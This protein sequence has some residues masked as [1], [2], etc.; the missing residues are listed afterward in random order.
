MLVYYQLLVTFA[1]LYIF[2]TALY[3]LRHML[4][5]P[6]YHALPLRPPL[7]SVLIPARNEELNIRLCLESLMA[8]DYP[9]LEIIVLDDGSS[10]TTSIIVQEMSARHQQVRLIHGQPL[11][12]DWHGKAW[13]CD[14]LSREAQGE[15]LLFVDADTRHRPNSISSAMALA[16]AHG[17]DLLSLLPDMALKTSGLRVI[18]SIIPFVF[19]AC[20]PHFAFSQTRWPSFAAAV[21]P[22]M[23]FRGEVYHKFGG[24]EAVRRDIV[25]DVFIA[26][27]VKRV[28]GR[29]ALAD[30]VS[31]LR[32]EFY[33][34][35]AE[36]WHGLAKS[37]FPTF[38]YSSSGL[39][40]ALAASALVLLGPYVFIYGAWRFGWIDWVHFG[41]PLI[42]ILL[43]CMAMVFVDGRFLVPRRYGLLVAL[44]VLVAILFCL[45]SA[46]RSLFG[47][48][49]VWK[50]R[51][52]QFRG[53]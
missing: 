39:M 49:T 20:V 14:Q 31:V 13:A 48:G 45:D 52:Y 28:G 53:R 5:L 18:M 17:L 22:F 51:A 33:R 2:L 12:P 30:G 6:S 41:L 16:C 29:V 23:L 42:Q 35:F 34:D 4:R 10:D 9:H 46:A 50:G 1:T 7:V 19:V 43:I 44:T 40:L 25:D 37:A 38:D 8:Q 36:A 3:N 11:P 24:H 27:C 21:G 15:W 47:A 32:V 26:R